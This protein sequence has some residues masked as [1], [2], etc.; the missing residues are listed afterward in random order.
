MVKRII[1]YTV[2]EN[3][4]ELEDDSII[5]KSE[6]GMSSIRIYND[7]S[8][9]QKEHYFL[10]KVNKYKNKSED[11]ESVILSSQAYLIITTIIS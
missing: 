5:A 9:I 2:N 10:Y 8:K 3:K 4:K 7:S 6:P 11:A 1:L